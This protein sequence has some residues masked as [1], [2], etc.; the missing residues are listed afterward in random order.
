MS[1][2]ERYRVRAAF[3]EERHAEAMSTLLELVEA[4]KEDLCC[5]GDDGWG[6]CG[7]GCATALERY[8]A[9]SDALDVV[10]DSQSEPGEPLTCQNC[11][12]EDAVT[13]TVCQGCAFLIEG[14][15]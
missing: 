8:S 12:S 9:L 11:G 1:E 5:P 14:E 3:L 15:S 13:I 7:T 2:S 4:A 10:G 6:T